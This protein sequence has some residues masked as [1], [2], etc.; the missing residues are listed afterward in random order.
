[1][2][3]EVA[4]KHARVE[5]ECTK[6]H[7]PFDKNAQDQLCLDCHKDVG[8]DMTAK[9]G[10][11]GQEPS[12]QGRACKSCHAE[13]KGR[14]A[15]MIR[16]DRKTFEHRA[17]DYTLRGGHTR[18]PCDGCHAPGKRYREAASRCS[19]CHASKDPHEGSV[20]AT[21]DKCHEE[22]GWKSVR[23]DHQAGAFPLEGKHR[24]ARCDACHKT[25]RYKP[26]PNT[27]HACHERDDKH[28]GH[29][30]GACQSC[31]TPQK[32]SGAR[33]DHARQTPFPLLGRH[34][35]TTCEKCHQDGDDPKRTAATCA[36]CHSRDDAHQGRFGRA[37]E[38][39]H[40]PADW[41]RPTFDHDRSTR[42][43]LRG[44]HKQA[45]C[46]DCHYGDIH[47][48]RLETKCYSCHRDEDVHHG[49]QGTRCDSCHDERG[50]Q[51]DVLFDHNST[52][53]PLAGAHARV[54]CTHCH[55]SPSF[56][57]VARE[58]VSCHQR[59][60]VHHGK[61]GPQCERCHD[62][63]DFRVVRTPTLQ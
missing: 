31:H 27:C 10:Y 63:S 52:P 59:E 24:D 33:F 36:S 53:F 7:A 25:K 60:D 29:L 23:L 9:G 39:C 11:H 41:R 3:G 1:M 6:C 22:S 2:P 16:L 14:D 8:A 34:A 38:T 15:E 45:R 44:R 61:K 51:R 55:L 30:G 13:H 35:Q 48:V 18:V 43:P 12:V 58:C 32:W 19:D 40:T 26:T 42:Y 5:R 17:T 46:A 20:G 4:A 54:P 49:R 37:C 47:E 62:T 28:H 56:K 57:N 50:W 21:C